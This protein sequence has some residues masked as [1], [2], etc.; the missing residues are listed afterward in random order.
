LPLSK[1]EFLRSQQ[2]IKGLPGE[3]V[4]ARLFLRRFSFFITPV[5]AILPISPN[6]IT[7]LSILTGITGAIFL[8]LPGVKNY[9]IGFSLIFTWYFLDVLDGDL[10]RFKRK[11]SLKGVYIDILGHYVVNPLI[12][13]SFGVY[14][15][16]M[17]NNIN[18]FALG[19]ASFVFH[20]YSRLASDIYYSVMYEQLDTNSNP[21]QALDKLSTIRHSDGKAADNIIKTL[22]KPAAYIFDAISITTV[23]GILRMLQS[24]Q[25]ACFSMTIY[26]ALVFFVF[27]GTCLLVSFELN[28]F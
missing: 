19:F 4:Y 20:Q 26:I 14:L 25:I 18:Y 7:V 10:A 2:E 22:R 27:L 16:L 17:F 1:V 12:F 13:S 6:M 3:P 24:R 8:M 15:A 23:F 5:I 9:Y 21:R 28:K 11:Q